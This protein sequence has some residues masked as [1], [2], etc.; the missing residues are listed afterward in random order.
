[1]KRRFYLLAGGIVIVIAVIVVLLTRQGANSNPPASGWNATDPQGLMIPR[2]FLNSLVLDGKKVVL[3]D[4]LLNLQ[5]EENGN[6]NG[7]G[8]CNSFFATYQVSSDGK[9]IFGPVGS[10][11]MACADGM[12]LENSY[13]TAISRVAQFR[14]ADGQVTLASADGKTVLTFNRPPK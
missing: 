6:V 7:E 1:M 11:K 10:T 14:T 9:L 2:W 8:G 5:F 4:K 13:F 12:E 3:G